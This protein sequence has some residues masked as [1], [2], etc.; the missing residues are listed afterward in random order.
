[1]GLKEFSLVFILELE[2]LQMYSTTVVGVF[3]NCGVASEAL[4]ALKEQGFKAKSLSVAGWFDQGSSGNDV[5]QSTISTNKPHSLIN[6]LRRQI[7]WSD[8]PAAVTIPGVGSFVVAGPLQNEFDSSSVRG[9]LK[10]IT[11]ALVSL[12]VP[13]YDAMVFEA[14]ILEGK[15][16]VTVNVQ[17]QFEK[18]KASEVVHQFHS[19]NIPTRP[20]LSSRHARL[21]S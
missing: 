17:D 19:L 9:M 6:R 8:N 10:G 1:M 13:E 11:A 7:G 20:S 21:A 12:D 14:L 2:L 3:D 4:L 18:L 16:L 5:S 15:L